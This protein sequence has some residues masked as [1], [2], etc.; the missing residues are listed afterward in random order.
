[1]VSFHSG[2]LLCKLFR[3]FRST[4]ITALVNRQSSFLCLAASQLLPPPR[5]RV[6]QLPREPDRLRKRTP[7][8]V[9]ALHR[10][11]SPLRTPHPARLRRD[12]RRRRR[13]PRPERQP[14]SPSSLSRSFPWH[15]RLIL[16]RL[17]RQPPRDRP[18]TPR[19]GPQRTRARSLEPS[20][21]R[22]RR[23]RR[24][25]DARQTAY[26]SSE[27][28]DFIPRSTDAF[29]ILQFLFLSF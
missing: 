10:R 16:H 23:G 13:R 25:S 12:R 20:L 18:P 21:R 8:Q 29:S 26:L 28:F 11:H 19:P 15:P 7:H 2:F 9:P 4:V 6:R 22:R 24:R 3:Y 27:L 5:A 1:M 17:P 14:R